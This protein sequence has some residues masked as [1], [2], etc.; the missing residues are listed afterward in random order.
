MTDKNRTISTIEDVIT[1]LFE[2]IRNM[3]TYPLEDEFQEGYERAFNDIMYELL[4]FATAA[5]TSE[6]I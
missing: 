1:Y 4:P 3:R 2:Q 6:A 5:D